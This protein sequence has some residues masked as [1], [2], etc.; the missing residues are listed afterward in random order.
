VVSIVRGICIV[1]V[2]DFLVQAGQSGN[3]LNCRAGLKPTPDTPLLID[4]TVNAAGLGIHD[5]HRARVITERAYRDATHFRIFAGSNVPRNE[6]LNFVAHRFVDRTLASDCCPARGFCSAPRCFQ[7]TTVP[8]F[9][10]SH[11]GSAFPFGQGTMKSPL[12][13]LKRRCLFTCDANASG[14]NFPRRKPATA[15][16]A[17]ARRQ[18]SVATTA[19]PGTDAMPAA[20]FCA[21]TAA[22]SRCGATVFRKT[23]DCKGESDQNEQDKCEAKESGGF[24]Y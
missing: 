6:S 12:Q 20:S 19:T 1:G 21:T 2:N 3:Q 22:A 13:S 10:A 9:D 24:I 5:H 4:E 7:I 17:T 23:W 16:P 11:L 15:A 8:S 14:A 18:S